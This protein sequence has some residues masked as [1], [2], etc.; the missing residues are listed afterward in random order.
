MD[1]FSTHEIDNQV[2]PLP[3]YSLFT[4]DDALREGVHRR[5][6]VSD[7]AHNILIRQISAMPAPFSSRRLRCRKDKGL[8][9][10]PR[11]QVRF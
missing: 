1:R 10:D 5:C 2:D 4:S 3:D 8:S 6:A 11:Y 9:V 7:L